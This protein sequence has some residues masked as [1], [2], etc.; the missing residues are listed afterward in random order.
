MENEITTVEQFAQALSGDGAPEEQELETAQPE[1]EAEIEE[2]P[3][4]EQVEEEQEADDSEES[5]GDEPEEPESLDDRTVEWETASGE[6]FSVPVAELKQGYMRTQDYTHKT[7]EL[8]RDRET[9]QQQTKELVQQRLQEIDG[10]AHEIGAFHAAH[11]EL[12]RYQQLVQQTDPQQDPIGHNAAAT[13]LLLAQEKLRGIAGNLQEVH[14]RRTQEQQQAHAAAQKQAFDTL[15]A[16]IPGF[17][18]ETLQQLNATGRNYGFT[19]DEL[20]GIADARMIK[21]LHDAMKFRE[22]QAKTDVAVKKVKAAP[23]K[24][25]KQT[26]SKPAS[27]VEK[28]MKQFG[29]KQDLNSFARLYQH[30]IK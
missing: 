10:Y 20:G 29:A 19:D 23:P 30:T 22:M 8:A 1:A 25:A 14:Q 13:Q 17:G 3:E 24:P 5:E 21:V 28:D 6:K 16:E 9:F 11:L 4:A 26:A 7:Q 27:G 18:R 12:Q 2:V 15:A